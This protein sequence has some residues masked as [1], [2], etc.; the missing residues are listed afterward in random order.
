MMSEHENDLLNEVPEDGIQEDDV[1]TP[2]ERFFS[3]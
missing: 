2:M 1:T 3:P